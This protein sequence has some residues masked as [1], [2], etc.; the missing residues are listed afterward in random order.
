VNSTALQHTLRELRRQFGNWRLAAVLVLVG[1]VLGIAGPFG[2]FAMISPAFLIAYWVVVVLLSYVTGA[3]VSEFADAAWGQGRPRWQR[4]L[5]MLLPAGAATSIVVSLL[6]TA[7]FGAIY[8]DLNSVLAVTGQCYLVTASI[9]M[10]SLLFERP[11]T[12]AVEAGPGTGTPRILERVPLPQRGKLLA[13]VVD[14]HYVDVVTDRGTTLVLMR[15]ADAIAESTAIRG[16]QIHRSHWVALDA[17]ARTHRTAGKVELELS[18]GM[19][20]P[21]SRGYLPAAREAGLG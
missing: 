6:N 10:A 21:V 8:V 17:V 13:L 5:I 4:V 14:D 9:V 3:A 12:A 1:I 20:L 7:I 18:N 16:L 19:R 2:T 11:V 15:L